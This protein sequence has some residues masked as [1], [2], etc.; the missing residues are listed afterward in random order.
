[1][2]KI[3][4]ILLVM[5]SFECEARSF[6]ISASGDNTTGLTEAKAWISL[7]KLNSMWG[8]I[9]AGD[10]VKF[11]CGETFRG[12]LAPTTTG[13]ATHR[14]VWM[15]YG[16]GAKPIISGLYTVNDWTANGPNKWICT[17]DSVTKANCNI[18]LDNGVPKAVARTPWM[19][20]YSCIA[21]SSTLSTLRSPSIGVTN[22]TGGEVVVRVNVY[23]AEKGTITAQSGNTIT[24]ANNTQAIYN[25]QRQNFANGTDSMGCF[26]QRHISAM[27]QEGE[28]YFNKATNKMNLYSATNPNTRTIKASYI[29]TL[30]TLASRGY[31]TIRD[32]EFEG[33]GVYAIESYAGTSLIIENCTFNNNTKPIYVW[34]TGDLWIA[35]N[36]IE[37]SFQGAI[38]VRNRQ[39]KRMMVDSN[40]V[41]NTGQLIGMGIYNNEFSLRAIAVMTDSNRLNNYVKIIGNTVIN[42]GNCPIYFNGSNV[43]VRRN[44]VDTF[45]NQLDDMGGIYT[46]NQNTIV[47][48]ELNFNR[49]VDS[50]FISNAIGALAGSRNGTSIDVAGLYLDDQADHVNANHNTI[51]NIPGNAVQMNTPRDIWLRDNTIYNAT[52]L[53][54]ENQRE[55]GLISN[56]KITKNIIAQKITSGTTSPQQLVNHVNDRLNGSRS[57]DTTFYPS[58]TTT[59]SIVN[60]GL[61]D[62]NWISNLQTNSFQAFTRPQSGTSYTTT[63]INLSTWKGSYT[64]D[65][66]STLPPLTITSS[67]ITLHPNPTN[68]PDTIEFY[69]LRKQDLKGNVYNNRAIIPA[70]SSLILID[71]GSIP[72]LAPSANAG[73]DQVKTL[74]TNTATLTGTSTDPEGGI[75]TYSWTKSSGPSSGTITS[76]SALSTGVTGLVEGVYQFTFKSTDPLGANTSDVMTVT[77]NPP[78]NTAPVPDAGPDLEINLPTDNVSLTGSATDA[79]GGTL[80]YHWT[81]IGGTGSSWTIT[82]PNSQN[83]TVTGL[84]QGTHDFDLAVTD[85]GGLTAH[86][87]V[88]VLVNPLPLPP[89]EYPVASAGDDI[90]KTLPDNSA[91]LNSSASYDPDGTVNSRFWEKLSGPSGGALSSTTAVSPNVTGLIE[92]VYRYQVTVTDNNDSTDNAIVTVTVHPRPANINPTVNGGVD[93]EIRLP[94]N[95]V[96]LTSTSSDEDGTIETYEWIKTDGPS[97]YNIISPSNSSTVISFDSAGIYTIK[98]TVTDDRGDSSFDYVAVTVYPAFIAPS[99]SNG[100]NSYIYLPVDSATLLGIAND[101]DGIISS[102]HWER[103]AGPDFGTIDQPDSLITKVY[104][105]HAGFYVYEMTVTDNDGLSSTTF[106][107]ISVSNPPV[108]PQKVGI[109]G[110]KVKS[111]TETPEP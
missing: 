53:I 17:P 89:N 2:K 52:Y 29:D 71:N 62:S 102:V 36:T 85:A 47:N 6:Y 99:V 103:V 39:E 66:V 44:I 1:M 48:K 22:W 4:A 92:G 76:P 105:L 54:N 59:Q 27:D 7:K 82:T 96:T 95:S 63:N 72:N 64:H 24:F 106:V 58:Q 23:Q 69:A 98:I 46:F 74:P 60:L 40:Y 43:T 19:K 37:N 79:E 12:F 86:D 50:N 90:E 65:L 94:V 101:A 75:L 109:Q 100:G 56:I 81:R 68:A 41:H 83:T 49:V 9:A 55:W 93:K 18:F 91:T 31:Y 8:A 42:T 97:G 13:D 26:I 35:R 80:T 88:H 107:T 10:T 61:I 87:V 108:A 78:P 11:H 16:T 15:S 51:W 32:L 73:S 14:I 57:S 110:Y 21:S 34:N 25:A 45:A 38:F 111:N 70:W 5:Y 33:A 67:N 84:S 30:V 104:D 77:V 20:Y 3:F 28:W